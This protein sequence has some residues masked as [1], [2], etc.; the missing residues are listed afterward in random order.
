MWVKIDTAR[1]PDI[2]ALYRVQGLP[3]LTVLDSQGR[4][5]ASNQGYMPPD[6]LARFLRK[7]LISVRGF[8]GNRTAALKKAFSAGE[9]AGVPEVLRLVIQELAEPDPAPREGLMTSIRN[10]GPKAW[11]ALCELMKDK[12]LG[13]RAAASAV[14]VHATKHDL[15]FDA[16][17]PMT[18]RRKQ[19]AAWREWIKRRKAKAPTSRPAPAKAADKPS[20]GAETPARKEPK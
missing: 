1:Q 18:T 9:P 3:H 12:R 5:L 6:A 17:A 4:Q 7:S 2:A 8:G 10:L 15:P 19:I 20:K 14:L 11:P 16:F 13:V